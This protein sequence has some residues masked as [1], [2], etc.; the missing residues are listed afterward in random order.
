MNAPAVSSI[1]LRRLLTATAESVCS[2]ATP[3]AF[4]VFIS[5]VYHATAMN[6]PTHHKALCASIT[7]KPSASASSSP[8]PPGSSP[9][10]VPNG[11]R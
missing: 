10:K 5:A 8:R 7:P 11:W 9:A 3:S 4:S 2:S 6:G 1:A